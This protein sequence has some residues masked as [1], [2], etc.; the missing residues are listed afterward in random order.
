MSLIKGLIFFL[1]RKWISSFSLSWFGGEWWPGRVLDRFVRVT[2]WIKRY[3][4][5]T[6]ILNLSDCIFPISITFSFLSL[7]YKDWSFD[8]CSL[9]HR[10]SLG[11]FGSALLNSID[12]HPWFGLE[13]Y[14]FESVYYLFISR[15]SMQFCIGLSIL[16]RS[17]I[18]S[19]GFFMGNPFLFSSAQAQYLI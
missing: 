9:W 11:V 19:G 8:C 5:M 10:F 3:S 2:A 7:P 1:N 18:Y 4:I 12:Y 17:W 16:C 14:F 13:F 15:I 6:G